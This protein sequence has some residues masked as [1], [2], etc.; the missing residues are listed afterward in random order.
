MDCKITRKRVGELFSYEWIAM[1][2]VFLIA[3]FLWSFVFQV[4]SVRV[5]RGQTFKYYVDSVVK[6][7]NIED[8]NK[9]L[10]EDEAL[11][12]SIIKFDREAIEADNSVLD[13]RLKIHDGD[14]IFSADSNEKDV[15]SR[16]KSL[17]D[18]YEIYD[19]GS[20]VKESKEY[21]SSFYTGD[22]LDDSK[23]EE[24]FLNRTKKDNRFR[25]N[26]EKAQGIILEKQ[27]ILDLKKHTECFEW[28][29]NEHPEIFFTY[30]RHAQQQKLS[31]SAEEADFYKELVDKEIALGR[32]N[33]FYGINLKKLTSVTGKSPIGN[34]FVTRNNTHDLILMAFDFKEYQE[35]EQ[36]EVISFMKTIIDNCS[37]LYEGKL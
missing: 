23:I 12:F 6:D 18:V 25:S 20:L 30:T 32:Q 28:L 13:T 11:S 33:A 36:F 5:T 21:I 29:M 7:Y 19:F 15:S 24:I 3:I 14:L 2:I 22:V 31:V 27:R 37:D 9:F 16:A 8:F 35:H 26:E 1:I 4:S 10:V 17:V 34:Y